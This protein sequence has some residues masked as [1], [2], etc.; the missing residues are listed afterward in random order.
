MKIRKYISILTA[1]AVMLTVSLVKTPYA[2][3][4]AETTADV[5]YIEAADSTYELL[6][7]FEGYSPEC[8]WDVAQ[9]TIGYGTRCPYEHTSNG[10]WGQKGGHTITEDEARELFST[11]VTY[12]V[13]SVRTSCKG[14]SMTQ[15]QFDALLSSAY[16]HG[17][18]APNGCS[19]CKYTKHPLVQYLMGNYTKEEAKSLYYEWCINR[20]TSNEAGLRN[21]RKIEADLF[22]SESTAEVNI[23]GF[24]IVTLTSGDLNVHTE[25]SAE[26][27]V[28]GTIP[29]GAK[30]Y[31]SKSNGNWLYVENFNGTAGYVSADYMKKDIVTANPSSC[32][33][34]EE[35]KGDYRINTHGDMLNIRSGESTLNDIVGQIPDGTVVTATKGN[36][37]WLYITYN[38]ISG[39][40]SADFVVKA[41]QEITTTPSIPETPQ[42]DCTCTAEYSGKYIITTVNDPLNIREKES[43]SSTILGKIPKGTIVNITK[44]NG[45]WLY[46]DNYNGISGHISAKYAS[47]Y[48]ESTVTVTSPTT[49]TANATLRL[50]GDANCDKTV[51]M[52]DAVLIMQ[53]ISNPSKYSIYGTDTTHI[54][55]QGMKNADCD[56][57][58]DGVTNADAS[59]IQKY[60]LGLG[61]LY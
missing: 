53:S 34:T 45:E 13:N 58:K 19:S 14:L 57:S 43:A 6:K 32:T 61:Q 54:T 48:T 50:S 23:S 36:G 29:N 49:T 21:R 31:V 7:R 18:I 24:F 25:P 22:F 10:S 60:V 59:A 15:N 52:S 44:G 11:H 5:Q 46:V 30:V 28:T 12:F 40:I 16:N 27:T 38:G 26:S 39:H 42:T 9:W 55:E 33:C 4:K 17:N 35:H 8:V 51:N 3:T 41:E 20:G 56:G 2:E 47:R 37:K 1:F